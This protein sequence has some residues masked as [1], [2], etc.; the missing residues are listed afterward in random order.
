MCKINNEDDNDY[1]DDLLT[2]SPMS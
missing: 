2:A 1:D